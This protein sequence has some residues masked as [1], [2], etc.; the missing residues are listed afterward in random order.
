MN[1]LET[2]NAYRA[3]DP[4]TATILLATG[5]RVRSPNY[6]KLRSP[7]PQDWRSFGTLRTST[8]GPQVQ[9]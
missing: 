7:D 5:W 8:Y 3:V 2:A 4:M 6:S 9:V 1:I